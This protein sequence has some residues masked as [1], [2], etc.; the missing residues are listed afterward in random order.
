MIK[1]NEHL[2]S[3]KEILQEQ[4]TDF[5]IVREKPLTF[6]AGGHYLVCAPVRYYEHPQFIKDLTEIIGGY[7]EIFQKIEW[8]S[9]ENYRDDNAISRAVH[10]VNIFDNSASYGNF[11]RK[12]LPGF[13]Q[14]WGYT[15]RQDKLF[16]ADALIRIPR[17]R[18]RKILSAFSVDELLQVFF[19]LFVFNYD[20]VQKKNFDL[21]SRL[22]SGGSRQ[23]MTLSDGSRKK[24]T[25]R[26][27]NYN[28]GRYSESDLQVFE[29]L[30]RLN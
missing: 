22:Q 29:D 20:I 3:V 17:M 25:L 24:K 30:S 7:Y 2:Y 18:A 21:L 15:I 11:I 14:R 5:D 16:R 1:V 19:T 26:M 27:P 9:S 10:Q 13:I 4:T 8:L 6:K 28:A 23:L 12:V